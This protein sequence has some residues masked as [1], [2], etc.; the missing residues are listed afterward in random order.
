TFQ[1]LTAI[2]PA[3]L[4][5]FTGTI[6]PEKRQKMWLDATV[7]FMT[8]Q[9]L[10]NDLIA[11]RYTLEDVSL[12]IF[13]EAHRAVGDYAYG[14][15]AEKYLQQATQPQ[16][17]GITASPGGTKAKIEE[18]AHNLKVDRVEIRSDNSPDVRPYIHG[19]DVEYLKIDL[20]ADFLRVSAILTEELKKCYSYLKKLG[21]LETEQVDKVTRKDLLAVRGKVQAVLARPDSTTDLTSNYGAIKVVSTA[22]RLSHAQELLETQGIKILDHYFTKCEEEVS[23]GSGGASLKAMMKNN[24]VS[25]ARVLTANLANAGIIHPKID[26]LKQVVGEQLTRSPESRVMIF[27]HFRDSVALLVEEL[28]GL[29]NARPLRFVGQ[30][31]KGLKDKGLKQKDQIQLLQE[32]REGAYNVLVATSVAE[33]GLDVSECDLVVFYDV[34]PS[35]IRTI[36]RRGRTGRK[37]EGRVVILVAKGTRDEAYMYAEKSKEKKMKETLRGWDKDNP[38]VTGKTRSENALPPGQTSLLKFAKKEAPGTLLQE[39]PLLPSEV[40]TPEEDTTSLPEDAEFPIQSGQVQPDLPAPP[41]SSVGNSDGQETVLGEITLTITPGQ[42]SILVDHRETASSVVK[43]LSQLGAVIT[44]GTLPTGDYVASQEVGIE[45]K[46][47]NDFAA[48]IID[49]RLFRECIELASCYKNPVMILEGPPIGTSAIHPNAIR[50]AI[51]TIITKL[52]ISVL[53]TA[54]AQDTAAMVFAIAKKAQEDRQKPV[55]I[56]AEK[57][58]TDLDRV[59]EFVLAGVPGLN[60][61]RTKGLLAHFGNLEKIFTA[62]EDELKETEGIGPKLAKQVRTAASHAYGAEKRL[63]KISPT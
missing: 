63:K 35:E 60:N 15:I 52:R 41:E 4:I 21:F 32:F 34:V 6:P 47:S 20:P 17:I 49:G 3:F 43:T 59:Q 42:V 27:A 9:V 23:T 30:Q 14:F 18:V 57:N 48:S 22:I 8:P 36:Q 37:R 28:E 2:D 44:F 53:Q 26:A 19:I 12:L 1:D 38:I 33:E 16:I 24:N 61:A 7:A 11:G 46:A 25:S 54:D 40:A 58:P 31:S 10:Q 50:A 62:S 13:D 51:A 56:R 45:R 29:E 5:L 55:R 39:P